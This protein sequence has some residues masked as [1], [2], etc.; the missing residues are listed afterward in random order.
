MIEFDNLP[1][2]NYVLKEIKAPYGCVLSDETIY[3]SLVG[4]NT[5]QLVVNNVSAYNERQH[6]SINMNKISNW[7]APLKGCEIELINNE[8]IYSYDGRLLVKA[9]NVVSTTI[10]DEDG[11]VFFDIDLP[12]C[13]YTIRESKSADGFSNYGFEEVIDFSYSE[14]KSQVEE[15][16]YG[17]T[18]VNDY[19]YGSSGRIFLVLGSRSVKTMHKMDDLGIG[20]YSLILERTYDY[21]G[22]YFNNPVSEYVSLD[23][24]NLTECELSERDLSE[25]HYSLVDWLFGLVCKIIFSMITL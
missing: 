10:S 24:D 13:I 8:D 17:K 4:D 23:E 9:G 16:I 6:M 2:G 14:D 1:L 19:I 11:G 12:N 21:I 5:K 3:V 25:R 22:E 20:G 7:G 15:L 18:L